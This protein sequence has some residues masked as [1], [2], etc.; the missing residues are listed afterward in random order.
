MSLRKKYKDF[1]STDIIPTDHDKLIVHWDYKTDPDNLRRTEPVLFYT[2][3]MKDLDSYGCP[4]HY[5]I[6]LTQAQAKLLRDWLDN[7]LKEVS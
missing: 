1:G 7:F 5:H 6:P 3:H 2:P 4:H